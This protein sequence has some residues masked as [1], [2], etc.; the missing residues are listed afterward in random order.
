MTPEERERI[1][2][3]WLAAALR[4]REAEPPP[5]LETLLLTRLRGAS[6]QRRFTVSLRFV[7]IAAAAVLAVVL[8]RWQLPRHGHG[9]PPLPNRST[10]FASL[11]SRVAPVP[12]ALRPMTKV[13]PER[14]TSPRHARTREHANVV[15]Q[16]PRREHFPSPPLLSEEN[17]LLL[18]YLR[19]TPPEEVLL[20]AQRQAEALGAE[21]QGDLTAGIH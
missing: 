21:S 14:K 3:E 12:T 5:G 19:T 18:G 7:S 6:R 13:G 8:G 10:P 17:Q 20:V 1:A 2:E 15:E 11:N 4:E 9:L 16:V